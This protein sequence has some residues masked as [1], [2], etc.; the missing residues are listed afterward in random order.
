MEV[1]SRETSSP[2]EN[3]R[4]SEMEHSEKLLAAKGD[5]KFRRV[6]F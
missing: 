2:N 3:G 5:R 1:G 6:K 4:N